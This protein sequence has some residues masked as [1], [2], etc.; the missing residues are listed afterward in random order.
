MAT[1]ELRLTLPV[2]RARDAVA[3]ALTEQGFSVQ[4]TPSGSLD[5]SRGSLGTTLV[6]GA[7]AGQDMHVRFDVHVTETAEGAIASFEHSAAGGFLKGGAIGA[8]KVGDVVREAAHLAGARLASQGFLVGAEGVSTPAD[9]TGPE[10]RDAAAPP[11]GDVTGSPTPSWP[12]PVAPTAPAD[13]GAPVPPAAP[14]PPYTA[15]EPAPQNGYPGYPGY[16][17]APAPSGSAYAPGM[18]PS[19]AGTSPY[20]PGAA[21]GNPERTN[22]VAIAAIIMGFVLPIGGIIAGAVALAQIKRTGEKGR[23]LA[24][25]GIIA[26]GVITVLTIL[27]TVAFVLFA[28]FGAGVAASSADPF[29]LPAEPGDGGVTIGPSEQ[30]PGDLYTLAVGACLDDIPSGFISPSNL[31]DCAQPHTYEVF[32]SFFLDDGA[33]P[34]DDAIESSAYEGCDAAYPDYV[35]VTWDQSALAY[36]FVSPSEETWAEGDREI[37]CLLYDPAVDQTTGSLRGAAR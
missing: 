1:A 22:G 34:G 30:A 24:I 3:A 8:A 32:G 29:D 4:S 35:G 15:A 26:G 17:G 28:I 2:D 18:P 10:A 11:S 25:G 21:S 33:F 12:A 6:A 14:A 37:S 16:P 23:G 9:P 31:V 19:A 7:F 13:S 36:S 5:V 20:A 27:A